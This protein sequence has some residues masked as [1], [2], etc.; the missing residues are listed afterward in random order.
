MASSRGYMVNG[1]SS[2][3]PNEQGHDDDHAVLL[4]PTRPPANNTSGQQQSVLSETL[5]NEFAVKKKPPRRSGSSV[6]LP[7][8]FLMRMKSEDNNNKNDQR[9][10]PLVPGESLRNSDNE[11]RASEPKLR[12][13][14]SFKVL[15]DRFRQYQSTDNLSERRRRPVV[16]YVEETP[17]RLVVP[18]TGLQNHG[19]SCYINAVFQCLNNTAQ[20]YDFFISGHYLKELARRN[21]ENSKKYGTNGEL[22][23]ACGMLVQSLGRATY[24]TE[25]STALIGTVARHWKQFHDGGGGEQ[26]AQEFLNWLLDRIHEDL[27]RKARKKLKIRKTKPDDRLAAMT[28]EAWGRSFISRLYRGLFRSSLTCVQCGQQSNTFDPFM[29]LSVPLPQVDM[30]PIYVNVVFFDLQSR[31]TRYGFSTSV[32]CSV[33]DVKDLVGQRTGI[34]AEEMVVLEVS[35]KG[36]ERTLSSEHG[37]DILQDVDELYVIE[38]PKARAS[39]EEEHIFILLMHTSRSNNQD[40]RKLSDPRVVQVSR[41]VT[42]RELVEAVLANI[43]AATLFRETIDAPFRLRL[44]E[45]SEYITAQVD[46]PL[47]MEAVDECLSFNQTST[48]PRHLKLYVEWDDKNAD[49]VAHRLIREKIVDDVSVATIRNMPESAKKTA[50][51]DCLDLLMQEEKVGMDESDLSWECPSC[52]GRQ[53]GTTKRGTL[54]NLPEILVIH[55]K[56][57]RQSASTRFKLTTMVDFPINHLDMARYL[58]KDEDLNRDRRTKSSKTSWFMWPKPRRPPDSEVHNIHSYSLFGVVNHTGRL[59][60]GHYT[61]FC[62]HPADGAWYMYDDL[63][64]KTVSDP[65]ELVTKDAYLLFYQRDPLETYPNLYYNDFEQVSTHNGY[66]M[67]PVVQRPS[68][69]TEDIPHALTDEDQRS[70]IATHTEET[71]NGFTRTAQIYAS[72]PRPRYTRRPLIVHKPVA[73]SSALPP[74]LPESLDSPILSQGIPHSFSQPNGNLSNGFDRSPPQHVSSAHAPN[75]HFYQRHWNHS[76]DN[77]RQISESCL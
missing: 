7:R 36:F 76:R 53:M 8:A 5:M 2:F 17:G 16:H 75:E 62:R 11:S 26:D 68:R 51:S 52:G 14:S 57:F 71:G 31:I 10:V 15:L 50:L 67:C 21:R 39:E 1:S 42:Y 47:Y 72:L 48:G 61:A 32:D 46:H 38:M 25:N 74:V 65:R 33:M 37:S 44:V 56:R 70:P 23:E 59:N 58:T 54:W 43:E 40:F 34:R 41:E 64:V 73:D 9:A 30:R 27:N 20:I 35:N 13:K 3:P 77:A 63:K 6:T 18:V 12:R 60:S 19:N 4:N 49:F 29:C 66:K 24:T 55:L 69:S 22:T 45:R 28:E